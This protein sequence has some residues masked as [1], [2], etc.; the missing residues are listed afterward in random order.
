VSAAAGG[1][2]AAGRAAF[3]IAGDPAIP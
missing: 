2:R 1:L 3:P